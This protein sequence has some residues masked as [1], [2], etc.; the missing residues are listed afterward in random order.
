[1]DRRVAQNGR[2]IIKNKWDGEAVPIDQERT[3][4]DDQHR[5]NGVRPKDAV[6]TTA[7]GAMTLSGHGAWQQTARGVSSLL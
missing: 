6:V 7:T 1:V 2:L 3:R 5:P 4:G